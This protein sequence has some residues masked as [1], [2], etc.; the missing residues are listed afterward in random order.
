MILLL[1]LYSGIQKA[2]F[3]DIE[4][5][6]KLDAYR[7]LAQ[8]YNKLM[9]DVDYDTW[10][11]YINSLLGGKEM[12][13]FEA[14]CGTG[15]MTGRLYDLGHDIV[16]SDISEEMLAIAI[17]DARRHGRDIVFVRQ[18]MRGISAG[19]RFDAVISAC[20]GPNYLDSEGLDAFFNAAFRMLK[21]GGRL[22]FDISSAAKLRAMDDEVYY[23]DGEET[24]CIWYNRF[25]EKTRTLAMEVT[26]FVR[27]GRLYKKMSEQHIQHAHEAADTERL[28][29]CAGFGKIDIYEAFTMEPVKDDSSRIQFVGY[30]E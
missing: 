23:D 4:E 12:R 1:L 25:N 21:P 8:R 9:A 28:L 11:S 29:R 16:A 6:I 2:M 15:S 27:E 13:L 19:N 22:M 5:D 7:Y 3:I 17:S 24:T 10:A 14:G 30:K 18:D 20:D 26:L